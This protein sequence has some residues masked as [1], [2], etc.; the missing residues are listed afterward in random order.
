[1]ELNIQIYASADQNKEVLEKYTELWD[2]IKSQIKIIDNKLSEYGKYFTKNKF[3]SDGNLP[4]NK[5]LKLYN[6]TI[7]ARSVFKENDKC[8]PQ[9]FRMNVCISYKNTTHYERN[10]H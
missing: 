2:G 7:M 8:Y 3:N 1:M 10:Q 9:F 4:L 5:L 6:L